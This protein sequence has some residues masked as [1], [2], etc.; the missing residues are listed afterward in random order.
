MNEYKSHGESGSAEV[1]KAQLEME[2]IRKILANYDLD[3][4]Y[5]MDETWYYFALQPD[6][7][8]TS[9]QL[10]GRRKD[11]RRITK[12]LTC[13]GTGSDRLPPWI[14]GIAENPR[15]FKNINRATLGCYYRN[16]QTAWMKFGI[17]IEF[18]L[19][20][21]HKM[22]GRKLVLCLDNL[23]GHEKDVWEVALQNTQI[24]WL[25]ANTTSK[26]QPMDQGII[27]AWKAYTRR[28][29]I[30]YLIAKVDTLGPNDKLP[31]S[32]VLQAI[33]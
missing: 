9:E 24:I 14:I 8:L 25:P 13:N 17:M 27:R 7:S 18:L 28:H 2:E 4:I 6:R 30:R 22:R 19:W 23:S 26:Y 12:A 33:H 29:Y 10:E 11:Q 16:N 21:D 32:S 31:I 3:D 1:E 5:N 15:C 20:F